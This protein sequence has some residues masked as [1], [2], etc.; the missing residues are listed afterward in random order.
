MHLLANLVLDDG[1]YG[2][3]SLLGLFWKSIARTFFSSF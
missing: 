1:V 3:E 2:A